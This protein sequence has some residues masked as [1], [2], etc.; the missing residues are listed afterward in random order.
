MSETTTVAVPEHLP[1]FITRPGET[2]MVMV[3]VAIFMV[4]AVFAVG[5]FYLKLHAIPEKM[6]HGNHRGQYQIV[7]ILALLALVSHNNI[8]WIAALLLAAIQ[9]PDFLTPLRSIARSLRRLADAG[10]APP[11]ATAATPSAAE[12]PAAPSAAS[13]PRPEES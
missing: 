5:V 11:P 3:N 2:D 12:P 8:F 7:A 4:L 13:A 1:Y 9:L 10:A 6:A